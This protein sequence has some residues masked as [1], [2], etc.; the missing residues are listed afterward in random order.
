[1]LRSHPQTRGVLVDLPATVARSNDVL[2]GAGVADRV[3]TV[4]QSF[5]DPLPSGADLYV[6]SGIMNDWADEPAIR[7]LSRCAEAARPD[8]SVVVMNGFPEGDSPRELV[9]EM[10]LCGGKDRSLDEFTALA[11]KAGLR[12]VAVNTSVVECKP[13]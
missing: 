12:V 13:T 9:V 2:E 8:A 7:I 10:L 4:G 11:H 3:T 6:L 5:F 1:M